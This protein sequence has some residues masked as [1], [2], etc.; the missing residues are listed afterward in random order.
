M[1][2][3]LLHYAAH[4]I[5]GGVENVIRQ[6]SCLMANAGHSVR[7]VAGRGAKV[8]SNVD[9]VS[10]PLVDSQSPEILG[11][12]RELDG[13]A[14]PADFEQLSAQIE[15]QL[16]ELLVDVDWIL[17]HNVC[18][19]N[20]N[21]ALTAALWRLSQVPS[22]PR[23]ALW[24]HDLAW[25]TPRYAAELHDGYP[26]DLLRT[27]WAQAVQVTVSKHRRHELADL[28]GLPED[29]I[30]VIPNGIDVGTFLKLGSEANA[31]VEEFQLLDAAP[32]ILMPVRITRRK[33][34]EMGLRVLA[35]LQK[36]HPLARL[37]VT[38]PTG[39]H[40]AANA[41]YLDSLNSL[42][43]ELGL[44]D[45][46]LFLTIA[47]G[48]ALSDEAVGDL[49]RLADMLLF[50][51]REEGFGIPI[52]EAGLAGI[53]VFSSEIEPLIELGS[54]QVTYFPPDG[55]AASLAEQISNALGA[56]QRYALRKR[57]LREYAWSRVY[58][59]HLAPLLEGK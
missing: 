3:A 59:Q 37:V 34:I 55:D 14:V 33:N 50:P 5:V 56:S 44:D 54:D 45:S 9:F 2:V 27:D 22:V 21:L 23:I 15:L 38:G 25:T 32:L 39:P 28:M 18:S 7:I 10:L 17:A 29:R 41:A 53:P 47:A 1:N 43:H 58:S 4:P 12:K 31:L 13:G 30:R 49:Y 36:R 57:V 40:N 51:S 46:A 26:W 48:K 35:P 19:L 52:L 42:Q 6:H 20:K 11:L 24:H 16:R 8:D